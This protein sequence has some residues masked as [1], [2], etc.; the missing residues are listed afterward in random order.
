MDF[1]ICHDSHTLYLMKCL[2]PTTFFTT[3]IMYTLKSQ[4]KF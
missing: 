4:V 1:F 3:P 2:Y